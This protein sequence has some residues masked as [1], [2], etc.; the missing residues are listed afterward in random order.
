MDRLDAHPAMVDPVA[1]WITRHWQESFEEVRQMLLDDSNCPPTLVA[2]REDEPI[3]VLAYK[4]HPPAGLDKEELWINVLYVTPSWRHH[5][6]GSRLV[7][8]GITRAADHGHPRLFVF[9]DL[10]Q[11]YE[12]L[13]WQRFSFNEAKQ[14]HLLNI[15]IP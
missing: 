1:E 15:H 4:C 2:V 3:G 5:G 14:M 12:R 6:I 13:G 10:P 9:T 11:F 7:R 8:E